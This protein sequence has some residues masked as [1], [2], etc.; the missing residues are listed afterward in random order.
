[1]AIAAPVQIGK[2]NIEI[3]TPQGYGR[4]PADMTELLSLLDSF[5][6][7][8]NQSLALFLSEQ[9]L[10]V[11]MTGDIKLWAIYVSVIA[12]GAKVLAFAVQ[13]VVFRIAITRRL[14]AVAATPLSL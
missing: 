8:N 12:V 5:T 13:Y 10:A 14:R 1:M 2:K 4:V 11:A 6:P 3:P 9:D 7:P